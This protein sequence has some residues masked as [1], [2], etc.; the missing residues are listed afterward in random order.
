MN[1]LIKNAVT[2]E[3][4][5][6]IDEILLYKRQTFLEA[7]VTFEKSHIWYKNIIILKEEK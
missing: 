3:Q 6:C 5:V 4:N 2:L 7:L 1:E